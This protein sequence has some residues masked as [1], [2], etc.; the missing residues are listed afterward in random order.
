MREPLSK[1]VAP[2]SIPENEVTTRDHDDD[3]IGPHNWHELKPVYYDPAK[4]G[5]PRTALAALAKHLPVFRNPDF[6]IGTATPAER[7]SSGVIVM[8]YFSLSDEAGALVRDAYD[9]GW[10]RGFDWMDWS[11]TPEGVYLLEDPCALIEADREDLARVVTVCMRS[12]HWGSKALAD[13]YRSGLL[14]RILERASVLHANQVVRALLVQDCQ[15]GV[16]CRPPLDMEYLRSRVSPWQATID[17]IQ[18]PDLMK[19]MQ[20]VL[21][22]RYEGYEDFLTTLA[23]EDA[24]QR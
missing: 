9:F 14:L 17:T 23:E 10:V 4:V 5:C 13:Y 18:A 8:G 19:H 20:E 15:A 16:R 7:T 2:Q 12:A 21:D 11:Q 22:A 3:T 6:V 1:P 24:R